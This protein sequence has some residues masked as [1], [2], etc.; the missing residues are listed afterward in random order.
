MKRLV[1]TK[2]LLCLIFV[3][4]E[5]QTGKHVILISIDGFRPAF[6]LDTT[7]PA[8]N[9][10]H[11]KSEGLYF[12]GIQSVFPSYTYPAHVAMLTGALPARG[13]IYYN[14]PFEPEGST[15]KWNWFTKDI[16]TATLWSKLKTLNL[17]TAAIQWPVSVGNDITY[18]I[19]EIWDTKNSEDRISVSRR[20]ATA[21]L[22]EQVEFN[23]TGKLNP[24]NMNSD[25]FGLDEN[26]GRIA[27]WIFKTYKPTF[28]A[29]HFAGADEA[30][31]LEGR[32]GQKVKLAVATIDRAI[33]NIIEML[34]QSKMKDSTVVLITG[35]HGFCDINTV[36]RPNVWLTKKGLLGADKNWKVKFQPAGGSAFLYLQDKNDVST[37]KKVREVLEALPPAIKSLFTVYDREKLNKMGADSNVAFALA[38]KPGV[39][40]G[41]SI[42]G[43]DIT[44]D[45][46]RGGH[47][48]YDPTIE[49]MQTGFI[50]FG[51]GLSRGLMSVPFGVKDI[52][53]LIAALLGIEFNTSDGVQF[54]ELLNKSQGK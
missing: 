16:K 42:Q 29:V 11:V 46:V 24:E 5:A 9:L 51:Q 38:A 45:N 48:G 4:A 32:N 50:A 28:L 19:P 25:G 13:G 49:A 44:T 1:L 20:Y 10:Q 35:D 43:D 37:A 3:S 52:A 6:Y 39:V 34:E 23:A 47:H 14:T 36:L 27:A 2:L 41:S 26:A 33:G 18:N 30:Q 40:F 53:P 17:T 12:N 8:P 22:V 31:H 7:W 54:T 21:G 15:G